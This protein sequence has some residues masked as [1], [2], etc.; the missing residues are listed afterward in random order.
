MTHTKPGLR[1]VPDRPPRAILYLR[2]SISHD[3]SVSLELQETAGRD[4]AARQGYEVTA[5]VADPNRTGRTLKRR[6]VSAVVAQIE[7]GEADVVIVWKWSRLSRLRRDFAVVVD[8]IESLGG[9]I[10]SSTEPIDI[11]TASGRF[12]RGM[13]A[14][15]SAYDSELKGE[16]WKEIHENL[17]RKG[18][19]AAGGQRFGYR[20][21]RGTGNYTIDDETGPVL[22]EMYRRAIDGHGPRRIALWLN[23]TGVRTVRGNQWT[24]LAVKRVLLS[25]FGAGKLVREPKRAG[26]RAW[27][28]GV[29]PAVITENQWLAYRRIVDAR[30][31]PGATRE[32]KYQLSGLMQCGDCGKK[33]HVAHS[34]GLSPSDGGYG[35]VCTTYLRN[36]TCRCITVK[37]QRAELVVK[38]FLQ[39]MSAD[40][41]QRSVRAALAQEKRAVARAHSGDISRRI[42]SLDK[43]LNRLTSGWAEGIVPDSAYTATR[44]ELLAAKGKLLVELSAA[45]ALTRD[46]PVA[47]AVP[48]G[49]L[50]VWDELPVANQREVLRT[51]VDYVEVIRP[52][53]KRGGPSRTRIEVVAKWGERFAD[54]PHSTT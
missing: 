12:A 34:G 45:E 43:Q 36:K 35:Y 17:W 22:T 32:P 48:A 15:Y 24:D 10:E 25:G 1:A 29:H 23:E 33:M 2:Q 16:V 49:L 8:L 39:R 13:M 37:R 5:V 44:D 14:E 38:E 20:H 27:I 18:K 50:D 41:E 3:D 28:D 11:R 47:P 19:P 9:R 30:L 54:L 31:S 51:L 46:V 52:P 26:K 6:Q 21:E 4:Y 7:R 53:G 42:L 40:V